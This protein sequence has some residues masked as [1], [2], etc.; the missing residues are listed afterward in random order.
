MH[1]MDNRQSGWG[2]GTLLHVKFWKKKFNTITPKN[3]QDRIST[4]NINTVSSRKVM[5]IRKNIN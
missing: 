2:L 1:L 3:D 4:Y 5:R